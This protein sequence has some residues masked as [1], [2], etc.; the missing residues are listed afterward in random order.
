MTA[1]FV[2]IELELMGYAG[3][4]RDL[5]NLDRLLNSLGGKKKVDAGLKE[6]RAEALALER[7]LNRLNEELEKTEEGTAAWEM[8]KDAIAEVESQAK[9]TKMVI[10]EVGMASKQAGKTFMQT[11]KS[12]SSTISHIGSSMQSLGNALNKFASP[13]RTL[14]NGTVFAAGYKFLNLMTEGFSRATERADILSTYKPVFKAM[15]AGLDVN[16]DWES[17]LSN[18]QGT[19]AYDRIYDSVIGLPTGIDE[20]V[21]EW[22]LLTIATQDY[23][24][25]ADLA[26]ASNNAILAS[27]ADD[28][29]QTTARREL[30]TL[31][32]TGKLTERQWD[33]LR[34]G[35]PVAWNAIE[36]DLKKNG[37]IQGSL[38]EALKNGDI[39]AQRFGELLIDEGING[40]TKEVVNEMLHTYNA[41]TANITNAFSNM[42]KNLLATLDEILKGA[43]G[44]DTIDYLIGMKEVINSFSEGVQGWM[45]DNSDTLIRFFD[46]LK[47]VDWAS[48]A[49]GFGEGLIKNLEN[50]SNILDRFDGKRLE[51]IGRFLARVPMLSTGLTTFGGIIKGLRIPLAAVFTLLTHGARKLTLGGKG[52]SVFGRIASLF[53]KRKDIASVGET[54]K[55]ISAV[56]PKLKSV[57]ENMALI[58]GIIATPAITAWITTKGIKSAVK[59]FKD[60]LNMLDGIVWEDAAKLAGGIAAFLGASALLGGAIGHL[61]GGVGLGTEIAIGEVVAGVITSLAAGFFDLDMAL[62]KDGIKNFADAMSYLDQIPDMDNADAIVEKIKNAID[63]Y[64]RVS[65]AM[66]GEVVEDENGRHREG[67]LEGIG[68]FQKFSIGNMSSAMESLVEMANSMSKLNEKQDVSWNTDAI[69]GIV[70]ACVAVASSLGKFGGFTEMVSSAMIQSTMNNVVEELIQ[71]R[72]MAYHVNLLSETTTA[73]WQVSKIESLVDDFTSIAKALGKFGG[74]ANLVSSGMIKKTMTNVVSELIQLRRMA[75]HINKLA[76]TDIDTAGFEE[77]IGKIKEALDSLK[78]YEADFELDISVKLSP[79]FQKSVKEVIKEIKEAKKKIENT[80]KPEVNVKIPVKVVFT[81]SSN[82]WSAL[83]TIQ[84]QKSKLSNASNGSSGGQMYSKP[85]GPTQQANGGMIYRSRGG[86]VPFRRRGTDTVPTMLTPGEYV[87]NKKAVNTFGIDFMRKVNNLDMKGAMTELMHRAGGMANINRGTSITNNYNN[88][89]RVVI[90]NS[91]NA[92]AGFTFKSASRFVGAF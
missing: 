85:I 16:G 78:S 65:Q 53:G 61:K 29:V 27:G 14:M 81:I 59:N 58:G 34:K 5:D 73:P 64:N 22:K 72:R 74:V 82:Y 46:A 49:K 63:V 56:T 17:Q 67:A 23:N 36:Q 66:K 80:K 21:N 13:F 54:A 31:M 18:P 25:A 76:S 32:T 1:E 86:N 92:G 10:S 42:G 83:R 68:F 87:H 38:L 84:N 50:M 90:N 55:T 39:S 43:T 79:N 75:Y 52:S 33:S 20:I 9:K 45:K 48:L 40:K 12:V 26:I 6:A 37:D 8:T 77:M 28:Q 24:K 91:N 3:V 69:T 62:I 44:K 2:G 71:L 11:F 57:L 88:N 7:E 51:S 60:T 4:K 30:R 47:N 89:Q 15:G 35:I 19:G 70:D 41:A